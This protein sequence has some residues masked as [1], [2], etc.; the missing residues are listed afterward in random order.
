MKRLSVIGL[1]LAA[2]F[3]SLGCSIKTVDGPVTVTTKQLPEASKPSVQ[4]GAKEVFGSSCTRVVLLI[5]PV[6]IATAE[7]A[8]SDALAQ[9]PGADTLLDYQ[10]RVS[11]V[12]VFPF[13]T[14]ICTEVH[15]FAVASK[16]FVGA[17]TDK[18]AAVAK[19]EE[20]QR[21]WEAEKVTL[22]R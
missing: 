7:G 8:Y 22:V 13:Y 12:Y 20:S 18:V 17:A 19:L 1:A 9:A 15:G 5:I 14:Q 16:A 6:G 11:G 4:E 10:A 2:I 21:K 3:S